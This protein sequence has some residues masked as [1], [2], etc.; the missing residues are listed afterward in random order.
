MRKRRSQLLRRRLYSIINVSV[1]SQ[2]KSSGAIDQLLRRICTP[3]PQSGQLE[4]PKEI[5]KMF[6]AKG[7]QR[8]Q[9]KATLI[10]CGGEKAGQTK[11]KDQSF[12]SCRRRS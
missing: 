10:S 9:L 2:A 1:A 11:P 6:L 3:K 8:K 4:V 7:P 12:H 5:Y